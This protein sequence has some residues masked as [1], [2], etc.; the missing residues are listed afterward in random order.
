MRLEQLQYLLVTADCHSMRKASQ[1]LHIS[2]QNISKSIKDLESE[3][4]VLLFERSSVGL[5]L[6]A[7][8]E[9][10]YLLAS[11]VC[12]R[13]D[14]ISHLFAANQSLMPYND[15]RGQFTAVTLPGNSNFLYNTMRQFKESCPKVSFYLEEYEALDVIHTMM[16]NDYEWGLTTIDHQMTSLEDPAFWQKYEVYTLRQDTF[17]V[18]TSTSS[19]LVQLQQIS[20]KT[21]N[22]YPIIFYSTAAD[23]QTLVQY[24]LDRHH[25]KYQTFLLSNSHAVFYDAIMK[26]HAI[27]LSSSF[28][29]QTAVRENQD[30]LTLLPLRTRIDIDHILIK[31]PICHQ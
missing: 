5:F 20:N 28:I 16:K 15:L 11:E 29:I 2:Q 24:L 7:A 21:L 12:E 6:T 8:G 17:K 23:K 25:I 22:E 3:L 19:P 1:A 18:L 26:N 27:A 14:K 30:K 10:V 31:K 9:K 4:N 13:A